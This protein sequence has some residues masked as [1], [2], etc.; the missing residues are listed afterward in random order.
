MAKRLDCSENKGFIDDIYW[1]INSRSNVE[2]CIL[3]NRKLKGNG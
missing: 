1:P 3:Y 2:I